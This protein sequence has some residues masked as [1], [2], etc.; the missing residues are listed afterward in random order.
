[1]E[2]AASF[3]NGTLCKRK[4]RTR[5]CT[6]PRDSQVRSKRK[7]DES[8]VL[9]ETGSHVSAVVAS[10]CHGAGSETFGKE[11][12]AA[13]GRIKFRVF[14]DLRIE[15]RGGGYIAGT[16]T[17]IAATTVNVVEHVRGDNH[18]RDSGCRN[19]HCDR[20]ARR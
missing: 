7:N 16:K 20:R 2:S 17:H 9:E 1:M 4:C 8:S 14:H 18:E 12:R 15:I 5:R 11:D 19:R 13:L 10:E 6:H 3:R